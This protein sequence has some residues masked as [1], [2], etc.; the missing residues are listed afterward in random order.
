M[1]VNNFLD[2]HIHVFYSLTNFFNYIICYSEHKIERH[3]EI[4]PFWIEDKDLKK[5]PVAFISTSENQFWKELLDKY[6]FP[7]DEDKAEKVNSTS[8]CQNI[9]SVNISIHL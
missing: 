5:G 8:I 3:D 9:I 1:L 7:I 6:L 4:N 2:I